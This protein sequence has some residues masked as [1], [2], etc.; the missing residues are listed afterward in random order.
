MLQVI[1]WRKHGKMTV[2]GLTVAMWQTI[3]QT[4]HLITVSQLPAA[5]LSQSYQKTLLVES[6]ILGFGIWKTAQGIRN[7]TSDWNPKIQVPLTKTGIQYLESGYPRRGIQNTRL[8]CI[9]LHGTNITLIPSSLTLLRWLAKRSVIVAML[10]NGFL[11]TWM[12]FIGNLT[13]S[14]IS[15]RVFIESLLA[16]I[17]EVFPPFLSPITLKK[18]PVFDNGNS[19]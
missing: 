8:S 16:K 18:K 11:V 1:P 14:A 13:T 9:P 19:F 2:L 10:S 12:N 5:A 17:F 6:G 15:S 3:S 4:L 7:P